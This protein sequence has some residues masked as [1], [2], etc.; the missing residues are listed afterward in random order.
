MYNLPTYNIGLTRCYSLRESCPFNQLTIAYISMAKGEIVLANSISILGF[1]LDWAC[2]SLVH[3]V[4]TTVNSLVQMPRCVQ[5]IVFLY[6]HM[7][8][9][10][11]YSSSIISVPLQAGHK[12]SVVSFYLYLPVVGV[13]VNHHLQKAEEFWMS[14]ERGGLIY[15]FKLL[16]VN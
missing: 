2:A 7:I 12:N 3:V 11:S 13:C 8:N 1:G 5:K 15:E 16:G 4:T 10:F 6:L 14:V 9:F